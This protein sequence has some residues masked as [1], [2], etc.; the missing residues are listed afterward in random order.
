MKKIK[1]TT[2]HL[3]LAKET[4]R[5]LQSHELPLVAG[6]GTS[7]HLTCSFTFCPM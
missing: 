5:D 1:K 2:K 3:A 7:G 6:G 4:V